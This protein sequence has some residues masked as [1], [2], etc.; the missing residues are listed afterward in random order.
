MIDKNV[1]EIADLVVVLEGGNAKYAPTNE[2]VN[3]ILEVYFSEYNDILICSYNRYKNG[4]IDYLEAHGVEKSRLLTSNYNY[5][6][7]Y[8]GT[9]NNAQEIVYFLIKNI[10]YKNIEIITSPYHEFRVNMILSELI[11]KKAMQDV[12]QFWFVHIDNSEILTTDNRRYL[13]I[14]SHEFLGVINFH[15]QQF[16]RW[17]YN[18]F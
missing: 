10:K 17:T 5:N 6:Y 15:I 8:G 1:F 16:R 4:I 7:N 13:Q 3:K 18:N 11:E 14:I 12:V 2:R 9:Y